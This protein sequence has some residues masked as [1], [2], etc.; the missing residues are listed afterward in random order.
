[1]SP[2][3]ANPNQ[4]GGF[5]PPSQPVVTEPP[6]RELPMRI[7]LEP[8]GRGWGRWSGRLGW[9]LFVL[10]LLYIIFTYGSY[11][12]YMQANPNI[13]EKFVSNSKTARDKV[14]IITIEGIIEHQDGFAK[15][16]IDRAREDPDVKA[17][18]VRVD[19]PGGTITGSNYLY[20]LLVELAKKKQ[21]KLV[22]SM[23]GLAASGGYYVSMAVGDTPDTIYAEPTTWTGSIGVVIPHYDVSDL[24]TKWDITDDS[25]ISNPLKLIGSPTRKVSPELAKQEHDI[26]QTLVDQSFDDFKD[27]VKSGR[28]EYKKNPEELDKLATGQVFTAKQ[29][30]ADHLVDKIG[31]I[32]DAVNQAIGLN[33]LEAG[34]V[35]VVK[36]SAPKGLLNEML[37]GSSASSDLAALSRGPKFDLSALLD[38]TA[39]RAYYLCTWLPSVVRRSGL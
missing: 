19:S 16:Q 7:I 21:I 12:S 29:A 20:H 15:W 3:P 34:S 24:L 14:A 30:L 28:P 36:Y 17:V 38:L 6:R 25:I 9:A 13:E 18:V 39:P 4:P 33:G 1:M 5:V 37:L 22:V 26:L 10:A 35:R 8:S 27:I 2:I 32:D 31:Y 11:S 23:G